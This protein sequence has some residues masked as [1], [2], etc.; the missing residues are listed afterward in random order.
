MLVSAAGYLAATVPL[1]LAGAGAAVAIPLLAVSEYDDVALGGA[2]V[3]ASLAPAV[4]AAPLVGAVMDRVRHPRLLVMASGVVT[5][6]AF[7]ATALLGTVPIEVIFV[8]LVAAGAVSPFYMGGASS[9]VTDEI[10]DERRAFAYDSGSYN[11]GYVGGPAIVAVSAV[12]GSA[13]LAMWL[14]AGAALAGAIA[15]LAL[16]MPARPQAIESMWQ[17]IAAGAKHLVGHRPLTVVI[18]SSTLAYSGSGALPIAAVALSLERTGSAADAAI[19]VTAFAIGGLVGSVL[20]IVRPSERF[21]P[22]MVMGLGFAAIG[23]FTLVAVPNLGL[24]WTIAAIGLSGVFTA[25]SNIAMLQLRKQQSPLG[26]RSQIFTIGAG[27]RTTAA[28][29][30]AAVAGLVAGLPAGILLAG[31][32]LSWL[33]SGAI[34]LL[35]PRGTQPLPED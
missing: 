13:V 20:A 24:G 27:L 31:I 23:A 25:S 1:R 14:M 17:T 15:T 4:V 19:I 29:A 9:F 10:V 18:A 8:L 6:V 12:G 2:L 35:Y 16:R 26:V 11:I 22:E 33:A 5:F 30:G 7:G 34:M 28:A 32:A 21:S 3:A